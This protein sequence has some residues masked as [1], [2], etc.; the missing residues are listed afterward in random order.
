MNSVSFGELAALRYCMEK[1]SNEVNKINKLKVPHMLHDQLRWTLS[2]PPPQPF[3][4]LQVRVDTKAY[5]YHNF[6]PP[7]PYRHRSAEMP[8]LADSGC[9]ASCM[10]PRELN[11]LGLTEKDLL[12]VEMKLNGANGS[13]L[14]ILGGVFL[15]VAGHDEAG[16]LWETSQLCYVAEGV[17][18]LLLSKEACVKLGILNKSFPSVGSAVT[19][20]PVVAEVMD[21][22]NADQFDLEPCA[23]EEDG[24]CSCPRREPVP[25]PPV[26]DPNLSVSQLRKRIIQHYAASAFN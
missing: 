21:G 24:S 10:G 14:R 17:E 11:K 18:K 15:V 7:S 12:E 23:P 4:K 5:K 22:P 2:H 19:D 13:Q 9:Q 3:I 26:F 20:K 25:E 6:K 16:K 1:V 8:V